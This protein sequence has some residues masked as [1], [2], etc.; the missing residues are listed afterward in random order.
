[1]L[2]I[3][4]NQSVHFSLAYDYRLSPINLPRYYSL[5]LNDI[6]RV[7]SRFVRQP[8]VNFLAKRRDLDRTFSE[9]KFSMLSK[10]LRPC[11]FLR[12]LNWIVSSWRPP[13][14]T[15][16]LFSFDFTARYRSLSFRLFRR[17]A[18]SSLASIFLYPPIRRSSSRKMVEQGINIAY[19]SNC[20]AMY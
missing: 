14:E 15:S 19:S 12:G 17:I 9:K 18:L 4:Y 6:A 1:M 3:I 7:Q 5:L 20:L 11:E 10:S 2:V 13:D 16:L 8:R